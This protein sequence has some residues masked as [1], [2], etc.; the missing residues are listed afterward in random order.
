[1]AEV[2][3]TLLDVLAR[4]VRDPNFQGT[5][6]DDMR[7]L[8]SWAQRMINARNRTIT[9]TATLTTEPDTLVYG[10]DAN[11]PDAIRITSIRQAE[12]DVLEVPYKTLRQMRANWSRHPGTR[13]D[14]WAYAGRDLLVLYPMVSSAVSL[15]VRY[16]KLLDELVNDASATELPDDELPAV[17]D[18]AEMLVHLRQRNFTRLR[19]MLPEAARTIERREQDGDNR[20][21]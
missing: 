6:R 16:V 14:L 1:M 4:R 11:F 5:P 18:L 3:G 21:G 9:K 8:L 15:E 2:A 12:R 7:T 10:V 20:L 13:F 17:L 19:E